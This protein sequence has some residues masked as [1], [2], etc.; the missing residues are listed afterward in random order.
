MQSSEELAIRKLV[1]SWLDATRAGDVDAV[2]ALMAPDAVFLVP[3]G[4]PLSGREAFARSLR[5]LL[6]THAIEPLS[7]IQEVV[8]D[9][10][11]AYCRTKLTVEVRPKD[12]ST[13]PVRRSGHT[14]SILRRQ[15]DGSWLLTVDANLL[16]APG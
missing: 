6:D 4:A 12:G 1:A 13:A 10:S 2:L 9:G 16:G 15:A 5:A 3:G 8:V 7:D 14:L 11:L